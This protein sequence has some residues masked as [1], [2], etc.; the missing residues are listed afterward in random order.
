MPTRRNR[1]SVVQT[2][3]RPLFEDGKSRVGRVRFSCEYMKM[4][5]RSGAD[6][7]GLFALFGA[8]VPSGARVLPER[9]EIEYTGYSPLFDLTEQTGWDAPE[10]TLAYNSETG[11]VFSQCVS[12]AHAKRSGRMLVVQG[13]DR[14]TNLP[15]VEPTP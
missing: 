13:C 14:P 12:R 8:F 5:V 6:Y 1:P 3:W 9:V 15:W 10:Y 2:D 4:A 7:K 11:A